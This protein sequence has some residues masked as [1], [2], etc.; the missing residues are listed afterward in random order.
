M[1]IVNVNPDLN[2]LL[3]TASPTISI[4]FS[5]DLDSNTINKNTISVY[6]SNTIDFVNFNLVYSNKVITITITQNLNYN[7]NYSIMFKSG[8]KGIMKLNPHVAEFNENNILTFKTK[9]NI[10]INGNIQPDDNDNTQEDN[11][12]ILPGDF[13]LI[14]TNPVNETIKNDTNQIVFTFNKNIASYD[15][16]EITADDVVYYPLEEESNI[17]NYDIIAENNT[18]TI[19]PKSSF[20]N[21]LRFATDYLI[22][23]NSVVSEDNETI[24]NVTLDFTTVLKP[25]YIS[26]KTIRNAFGD[27]LKEV[28]DAQLELLIYEASIYA[29]Q[30]AAHRFPL[31]KP[32]QTVIQFVFCYVKQ[33][34]FDRLFI[35]TGGGVNSNTIIKRK[36]LADFTI[37]YGTDQAKFLTDLLK[38]IN[39]CVE[40]MGMKLGIDQYT[41]NDGGIQ[42]TVK[43]WNDPRK[44][45]Y[46]NPYYSWNRLGYGGR[47]SFVKRPINYRNARVKPKSEE[48]TFTRYF[49]YEV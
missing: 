40:S 12:N 32:T 30:W 9:P 6:N 47:S 21:K 22:T 42:A 29:Y 26:V 31:F 36:T 3:S 33:L 17:N 45:I 7:T 20:H 13:K 10:I 25:L 5:D 37:E 39:D 15:G 49:G 2:S 8:T 14:N 46:P 34:L 41:V 16:I 28:T 43:S 1:S 38:R 4:T 11:D 24:S 48:L 35:T 27:L 23:I 18:L 19:K 44:P